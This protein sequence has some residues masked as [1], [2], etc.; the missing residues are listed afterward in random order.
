MAH[1]EVLWHTNTGFIFI[2]CI[3]LLVLFTEYSIFFMIAFHSPT[4]EEN[5]VI[6]LFYLKFLVDRFTKPTPF[7][8]VPMPMVA[9]H[10]FYS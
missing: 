2:S 9:S 6:L 10:R 5:G 1:L 8:P 7:L 4:G 3:Y